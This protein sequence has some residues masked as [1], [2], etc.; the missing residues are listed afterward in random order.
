MRWATGQHVPSAEA[1]KMFGS[2]VVLIVLAFLTRE[3]IR[4]QELPLPVLAGFGAAGL[5]RFF[6]VH[7]FPAASLAGGMALG[8]VLF[9]GSLFTKEAVGKGDGLLLCAIGVWL[10]FS[11]SLRLLFFASILSAAA[12]LF[13]LLAAKKERTQR[14]PFV[15]F[16]LGAYLIVLAAG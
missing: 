15:P 16:L 12:A 10:G 14:I 5:M 7:P 13:L 9:L 3:D 4:K 2:C 6:F 8:A 11:Q 1:D